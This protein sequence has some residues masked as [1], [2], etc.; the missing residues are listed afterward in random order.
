MKNREIKFR[1]WDGLRMTTGGIMFNTSTGSVVVPT[2]Q[3][4]RMDKIT[5][6]WHLMEFTGLYDN[7]GKE[8][9]EGDLI[10]NH[11]RNGGN[12]HPVIYHAPLAA[13]CGDYG[14]KYPLQDGE[15]VEVTVVGNIYQH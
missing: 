4:I 8:I 1:A 6:P 13:W 12:P 2:E 11:S 3:S 7:A 10:T 14:N 15:L 5:N 9:W